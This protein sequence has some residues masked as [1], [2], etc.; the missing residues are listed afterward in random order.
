M[1]KYL[2]A[3][4]A[5]IG[6]LSSTRA[7]QFELEYLATLPEPVANNA[8]AVAELNGNTY[9]YSFSG[10][11]T[12]K[13]FSGIHLNSYCYDVTNGQWLTV[14]PVP[15]S[16]GLVAAG[17]TY[18]QGIVYFVGGYSVFANG[19]ETSS[20][21]VQRLDV[22]TNTW[23]S[24]AADIP[25]P[26]DDHVQ[27]L[28]R[29]SL[30]FIVTGWSNTGNVPDVQIYDPANDQWLTGTSVPANN[31]F[32]SFGPSGTI[33]GDTIYYLGGAS[34]GA[35]FPAQNQLRK[36][37]IDPA[38]PS[39]ITWSFEI[40]NPN[41][42]C[43]RCGTFAAYTGGG[44]P[45]AVWVGGSDVTYNYNGIAYNGS[46][47]VSPR[48]SLWIYDPATGKITASTFNNPNNITLPMDLR[49]M[50]SAGQSNGENEFYIM[51]G[52]VA[53]Q[54]VSD[55]VLRLT[56]RPVR[57]AE[58]PFTLHAFKVYPNPATDEFRIVRKRSASSLLSIRLINLKGQVVR[59]FKAQENYS[60]AGLPE[61]LYFIEIETATDRFY[62]KLL[63]Q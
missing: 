5:V 11:D 10:I 17:A 6:L 26:I 54:T 30:L 32:R 43:Y 52:M 31:A 35:A 56:A 4:C 57:V 53:N 14:P 3:A 8:M 1:L 61:G 9:L 63:H 39:S 27:A 22:A 20:E 13:L 15:Q 19:S 46:G 37:Y 28:W 48:D 33:I 58:V 41:A 45:T 29:D 62:Q 18:H 51:G 38:S 36:G 55:S 21:K 59:T 7:Q 24:D 42:T 44:T 34:M 47:G 23:L 12:S 49:H 60:S 40:P 2:V 16:M 50:T 25:V